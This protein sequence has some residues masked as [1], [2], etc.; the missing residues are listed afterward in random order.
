MKSS[1]A[2]RPRRA[3]KRLGRPRKP[4][5]EVKGTTLGLRVTEATRAKM[6]QACERSG[7]S[8]AQE[9]EFRLEQSYLLD[10]VTRTLFGGEISAQEIVELAALWRDWKKCTKEITGDTS[11]RRWMS[12]APYVLESLPYEHLIALSD[13]HLGQPA[14]VSSSTASPVTE[15]EPSKAL[16]D[17]ERRFELR[18]IADYLDRN[19]ALRAKHQDL[20]EYAQKYG[21]R[22]R[23]KKGADQ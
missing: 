4:R 15:G 17:A 22:R 23:E 18:H 7:R 12:V 14:P 10:A 13:E 1:L 8:L 19:P 20:Y 9:A 16:R 3:S 21:E 5:D 11:P 6:D 2:L